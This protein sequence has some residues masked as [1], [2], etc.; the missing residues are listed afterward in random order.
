MKYPTGVDNCFQIEELDIG[1]PYNFELKKPSNVHE[2]GMVHP[3]STHIDTKEG[4]VYIVDVQTDKEEE[5]T[6]QSIDF[7]CSNI[8][9]VIKP[10]EEIKVYI[11]EFKTGDY[12]KSYYLEKDMVE[13]WTKAAIWKEDELSKLSRTSKAIFKVP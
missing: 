9:F 7:V 10:Y 11:V 13:F 3:Q 8:E 4:E 5:I 6:V 1:I 2:V 12:G